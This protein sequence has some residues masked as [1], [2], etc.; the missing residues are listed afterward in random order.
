MAGIVCGWHGVRR[1]AGRQKR[2]EMMRF[3]IKS[4]NWDASER[5]TLSFISFVF[6]AK[7]AFMVSG[8]NHRQF[9]A[10]AAAAVVLWARARREKHS[11]FIPSEKKTESFRRRQVGW[12]LRI[13]IT[14]SCSFECLLCS[15]LFQNDSSCV[16]WFSR[17]RFECGFFLFSLA[18]KMCVQRGWEVWNNSSL[19]S[20]R[21]THSL[22]R[23][24]DM[25][26]SFPPNIEWWQHTRPNHFHSH[27]R[28]GKHNSAYEN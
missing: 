10:A 7:R 13:L 9:T 15:R 19:K 24:L 12:F 23:C 14:I 20:S 8:K 16:W 22:P 25:R 4:I 5:E 3:F 11:K 26:G 1:Q 28:H 21:L 17:G 2:W 6:R 27:S 18:R